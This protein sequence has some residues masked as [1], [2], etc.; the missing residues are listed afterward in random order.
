M[1]GLFL[2]SLV[3]LTAIVVAAPLFHRTTRSVRLSTAGLAL[4]PVD[5]ALP[6]RAQARQIESRRAQRRRRCEDGAGGAWSKTNAAAARNRGISEARGE[7]IA[8]LEAH[9]IGHRSRQPRSRNS[10]RRIQLFMVPSGTLIRVA[11]SS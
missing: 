8:F 11:S 5:A 10:P 9:G 3:A 6:A 4:L 2:V 7:L 1:I